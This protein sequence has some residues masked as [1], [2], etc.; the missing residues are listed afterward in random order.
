MDLSCL[1]TPIP[2]TGTTSV[3]PVRDLGR[4]P[5]AEALEQQRS[6]QREVIAARDLVDQP[7]GVLLLLEHDP[8]VVT[9]SRRPGAGHHLVA[10]EAQLAAAGVE[11]VETDRGGDITYHGPGQIVGYPI[12]DLNRLD[13]RLHGYLRWMEGVIIGV[14]GAWG[15][16][17]GR[18]DDATGVWVPAE[19]A[20]AKICAM[21]VR[22]SRWVTMHGFALNVSTDLTHFDLI[23]PCGLVGRSVT[24]LQ[25]ELGAAA[26]SIADVKTALADAFRRAIAAADRGPANH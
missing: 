8:P 11:V 7:P 18:D 10:S 9:I 16:A 4:I 12:L 22:V 2:A 26:P 21:G 14:L 24:S 5:Y 15:I 25:R 19:P 20:P 3:L 17:A 6:L 23:V 13:L 1:G